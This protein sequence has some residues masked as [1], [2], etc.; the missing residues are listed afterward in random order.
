MRIHT[1]SDVTMATVQNAA[2]RAGVRVLSATEHASR[3]GGHAFNVALS[4]S[5]ARRT[6]NGEA[7]GATWDEWG[8]FLAAIFDADPAASAGGT[9]PDAEAFHWATGGRFRE[10]LPA[11]QCA[12]RG[13]APGKLT[14]GHLWEWTGDVITGAYYVTT[15]KRCGAVHRHLSPG[16][17]WADVLS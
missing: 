3:K 9:Y 12:G 2:L 15:C 13:W 4:G 14:S 1:S 5:N 10:L 16:Y 7:H 17:G 8:M 6:R 11:G